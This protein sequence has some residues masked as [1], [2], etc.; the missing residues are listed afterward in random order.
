MLFRVAI[1]EDANTSEWSISL[2]AKVRIAISNGVPYKSPFDSLSLPLDQ[3]TYRLLNTVH[4]QNNYHG[5]KFQHS[6][7][8][9]WLP[10]VICSMQ[11][12][13]VDAN[14]RSHMQQHYINYCAI[15]MQL[16]QYCTQ[17]W[18]HSSIPKHSRHKTLICVEIINNKQPLI[19]ALFIDPQ[20][21]L[22]SWQL[23]SRYSHIWP[24]P[25]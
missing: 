5:K 11:T 23:K 4:S 10:T 17:T 15:K 7:I 2:R 6:T 22:A 19:H 21:I 18:V 20:Q 14:M 1:K 13:H 25:V 8:H 3:L 12:V 16:L 9:S 24:Q